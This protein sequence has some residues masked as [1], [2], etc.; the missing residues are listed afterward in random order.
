MFME[1]IFNFF[2]KY[3]RIFFENPSVPLKIPDNVPKIFSEFILLINKSKPCIKMS[4]R[5]RNIRKEGTKITQ[6]LKLL[7]CGGG[8][9]VPGGGT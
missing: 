3:L 4:R 7:Y 9:G 8:G 1:I 6:F 5:K 2:S